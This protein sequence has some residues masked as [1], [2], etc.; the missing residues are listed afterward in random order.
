[1]LGAIRLMY[2]GA[3]VTLVDVIIGSAVAASYNAYWT[4]Y[5]Y[6][7]P[8]A[9][10]HHQTMANI[11]DTTT[12]LGGVIGIVCWLVIAAA[13]RRGHSWTRVAG[14][15]LLALDTACLLTVMIGTHNDPGVKAAS[16]VVWIIGLSAVIP[17]WG[18]QASNFFLAFR[19]R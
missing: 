3:V 19:K 10:Q 15:V 14:T 5:Q 1:V 18:R 11:L 8:V 12:A 6:T 2:V 9:A 17:L 4:T 13:C 7:F 16:L